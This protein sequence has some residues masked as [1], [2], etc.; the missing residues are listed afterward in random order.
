MKVAQQ[1]VTNHCQ[2]CLHLI[3]I[4]KSVGGSSAF[5]KTNG[6]INKIKNTVSLPSILEVL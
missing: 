6:V 5:E 2:R 3:Q 1:T 4:K